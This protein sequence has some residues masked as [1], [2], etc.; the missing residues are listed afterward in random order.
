LTTPGGVPYF[1]SGAVLSGLGAYLTYQWLR[2]HRDELE[3]FEPAVRDELLG[4]LLAVRRASDAFEAR[5]RASASGSAEGRRVGLVA[6]SV[7]AGPCGPGQP[8]LGVVDVAGLLGVS[9]RR[10]RQMA[11]EGRLPGR[12]DGQRWVFDEDEVMALLEHRRET[13]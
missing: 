5:E 2:M 1:E 8:G 10:V 13:A 4:V 3:L 12:K 11:E 9:R 6:R 7:A